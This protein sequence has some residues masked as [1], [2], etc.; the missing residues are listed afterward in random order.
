MED[1]KNKLIVYDSAS[2]QRKIYTIRDVQVMLDSDLAK[3]YKVETRRLN[4]Q[5]RRNIERFPEE[6]MFRLTKD[7]YDN[8]MSQIAISSTKYGGR[9]KL[10]ENYLTSSQNKE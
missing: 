6:F 8:L 1:S 4:E 3:F 9:R 10:E 7:E 5:V 2:I